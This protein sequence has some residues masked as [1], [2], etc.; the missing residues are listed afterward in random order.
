MEERVHFVRDAIE[1]ALAL[2]DD[3]QRALAQQILEERGAGPDA[4]PSGP[5]PGMGDRPGREPP[6]PRR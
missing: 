1:R 4:Q 2:L 5:P 3:D 6:R